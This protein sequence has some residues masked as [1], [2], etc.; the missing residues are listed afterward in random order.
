LSEEAA[1]G[2][3][4]DFLDNH[5]VYLVISPRAHGLSVGVNLN[6]LAHCNLNCLYCEVDRAQPARGAGLEIHRMVMELRET[7]ELARGGWLRQWPRYARLPAE[8]LAVRHVALSG[9]GEPTLSR[10]FVEAVQAVVRLRARDGHFKIVLPTNATALEQAPAQ[11]GL[12]LLG[13]EDEVWAKL[14]GG[15]QAYLDRINGTSTPLGKILRNILM[16]GRQRPVIIQSLFPALNGEEPPASEIQAYARRLKE[17]K[18]A[19]A[20]IP[21]VQI[22]SANRPIA[23]SGCGH[24]PLKTLSQIAQTVRHVAGLRAEV[25]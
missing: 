9:D 24:L 2:Y 25:F 1:F 13:K 7:L 17:L 3:P 10:Q 23:R 19:G 18:S 15:T 12:A 11:Q 5:F 16:V 22:Y 21:L 8:L 4:R 14:D 20:E 6:P